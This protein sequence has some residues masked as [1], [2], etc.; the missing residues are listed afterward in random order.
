[1]LAGAAAV[2]E[3]ETVSSQLA[4]D[5]L[6]FIGRVRACRDSALPPLLFH[7]GHYRALGDVLVRANA[8]LEAEGL[9]PAPVAAA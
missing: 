8:V 7:A 9:P 4:G 5:H 3:C 1:V 2:F 6:L